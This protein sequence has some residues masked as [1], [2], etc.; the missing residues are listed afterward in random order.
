VGIFIF[1]LEIFPHILYNGRRTVNKGKITMTMSAKN[2]KLDNKKRITLGK[3]AAKNITSYDVELKDN[4]VIVLYP[5]VEIS[6]E[7]AWLL[8]NKEA[9]ASV[10][11]GLRDSANG[12]I[13]DL[14]DEFWNDIED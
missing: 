8:Q 4:G 10:K 7:E 5:K 1:P 6:M 3:L 12:D 14:E 2:L 13:S 11:R 9:L